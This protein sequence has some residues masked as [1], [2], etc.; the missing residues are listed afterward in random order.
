MT[1]KILVKFVAETFCT[2]EADTE[3]DIVKAV[4]N[5]NY[6]AYETTAADECEIFIIEDDVVRKIA[7][8]VC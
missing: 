5:G 1:K 6:D 7:D 8:C 2:V 3:E 4:Q